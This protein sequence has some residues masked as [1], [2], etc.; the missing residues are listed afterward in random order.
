MFD[1]LFGWLFEPIA[2]GGLGNN[3]LEEDRT[4]AYCRRK[5]LEKHA[6]EREDSWCG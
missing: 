2:E 3:S 4:A 6:Q 5:E 1:L